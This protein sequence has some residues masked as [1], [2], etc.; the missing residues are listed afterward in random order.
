MTVASTALVLLELR[1][2]H[3][4]AVHAFDLEFFVHGYA[5]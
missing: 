5:D 1:C 4:Q 3:W 2:P